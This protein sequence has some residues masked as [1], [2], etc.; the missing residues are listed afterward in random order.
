[1]DA[2]TLPICLP[3]RRQ[4]DSVA[5][6]NA[7]LL[8]SQLRHPLLR[9]AIHVNDVGN[10]EFIPSSVPFGLRV[11]RR[12]DRTQWLSEV[13]TELALPFKPGNR[14]LM[15]VV[16]VQEEAVSELIL[17]VH[18]SVMAGLSCIS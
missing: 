17:A 7:A 6:L 18:L 13:D 12:A 8:Q 11:V 3:N 14:L 9:T 16:L 4:I 10:P 2:T 5:N 15:R 1:M